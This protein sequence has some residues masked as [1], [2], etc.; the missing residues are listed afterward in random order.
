MLNVDNFGVGS[1]YI[2]VLLGRSDALRPDQD[3]NDVAV[4]HFLALAQ[5]FGFLKVSLSTLQ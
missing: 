5:Y 2:F 3:S 4:D 1:R